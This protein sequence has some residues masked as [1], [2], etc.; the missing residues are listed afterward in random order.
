MLTDLTLL[1]SEHGGL[2]SRAQRNTVGFNPPRALPEVAFFVV[3]HYKRG[4]KK[5]NKRK[6]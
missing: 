4:I 2:A 1:W 3:A 5:E 6:N